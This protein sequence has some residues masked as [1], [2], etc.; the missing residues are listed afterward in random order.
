MKNPT[1]NLRYKLVERPRFLLQFNLKENEQEFQ[2]FVSKFYVWE[3]IVFLSLK[4]IY[5]SVLLFSAGWRCYSP[6]TVIQLS[7]VIPYFILS[8]LLIRY[9]V[10]SLPGKANLV[11]YSIVLVALYFTASMAILLA[12]AIFSY[13]SNT[14]AMTVKY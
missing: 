3:T 5:D 7:W 13:V 8:I 10:I 4:A 1:L 11:F 2:Q 6:I 12:T 14:A 9:L